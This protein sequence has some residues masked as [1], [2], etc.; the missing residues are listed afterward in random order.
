MKL[1]LFNAKI[2]NET[3]R[4]IHRLMYQLNEQ[5]LLCHSIQNVSLIML[6]SLLDGGLKWVNFV[7]ITVE[8][9][10]QWLCFGCVRRIKL[11]VT[12]SNVTCMLRSL[13]TQSF[14]IVNTLIILLFS[15]KWVPGFAA[16]DNIS[17][18]FE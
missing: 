1:G 5:D 4:Y 10:G 3:R 9:Q 7:I 17:A 13:L 15:K 2:R 8:K 12:C 11:N 6:T 16:E 14:N 18:C